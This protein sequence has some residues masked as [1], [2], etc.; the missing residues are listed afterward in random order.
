MP[1]SAGPATAAS[2]A[3]RIRAFIS[4]VPFQVSTGPIRVSG[5]RPFKPHARLWLALKSAERRQS[6]HARHVF[7]RERVSGPRLAAAVIV[8]RRDPAMASEN[9]DVNAAVVLLAAR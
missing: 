7:D 1:A 8:A 2:A 6:R 4:S 5:E 3:A 9:F